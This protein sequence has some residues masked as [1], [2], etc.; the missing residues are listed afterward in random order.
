NTHYPI[1]IVSTGLKDILVPIK[2]E[3]DLYT[4]EPNFEEVKKVSKHYEV[5]G[6]HLYTFSDDRIICRNFAPLFDINEEA[7]TGT[8]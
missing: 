1:Q 7:A 5:V 3:A 2:S 8:S 4:L 6:M